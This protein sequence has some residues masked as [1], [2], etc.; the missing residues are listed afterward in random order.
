MEAL[1]D[2]NFL[3]LTGDKNIFEA[4]FTF[5]LHYLSMIHDKNQETQNELRRQQSRNS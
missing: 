2:T 1:A 3:K 4:N 5:G